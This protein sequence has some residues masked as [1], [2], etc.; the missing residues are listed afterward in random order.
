MVHHDP[1]HAVLPARDGWHRIFNPLPFSALF[2]TLALTIGW[3]G[4]LALRSADEFGI[5]LAIPFV[6]LLAAA[7]TGISLWLVLLTAAGAQLLGGKLV[8]LRIML[9]AI[10]P[11][12]IARRLDGLHV[13]MHGS[14]RL[15]VAPIVFVAPDIHPTRRRFLFAALFPAMVLL[16]LSAVGYLVVSA[17]VSDHEAIHA[18]A[19]PLTPILV[20]P[21]GIAVGLTLFPL[22]YIL[23]ML[24]PPRFNGIGVPLIL[25]RESGAI[26][27][28]AIEQL[29]H[30]SYTGVRPRDW[31]EDLIARASLPGIGLTHSAVVAFGTWLTY[32]HALDKDDRETA[33]RHL[34]ATLVGVENLLV[35]P[36]RGRIRLA[37]AFHE[38]QS[39]NVADARTWL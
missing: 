8:R 1:A 13:G 14:W 19:D 10:G 26:R 34:D 7:A 25:P 4:L 27:A 31:P 29:R 35:S 38:A 21:L 39:G 37:V 33:R 6:A 2:V 15:L 28:E 24:F 17:L 22:A 23:L 3:T 20:T 5:A 12:L 9:A 11:M 30:Q 32:C 16:A 18:I 36:F